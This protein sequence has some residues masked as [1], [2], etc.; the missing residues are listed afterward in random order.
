MGTMKGSHLQQE[1][2][3]GKGFL[4]FIELNHGSFLSGNGYDQKSC[5]KK[6]IVPR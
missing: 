2:K 5:F 1:I 6:E 4:T 3:E